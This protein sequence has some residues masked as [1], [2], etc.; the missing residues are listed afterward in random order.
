MCTPCDFVWAGVFTVCM[1]D[2]YSRGV[3]QCARAFVYVWIVEIRVLVGAD[4][5][6]VFG[7][8]FGGRLV[9]GKCEHVPTG[10][11][12]GDL[13]VSSVCLSFLQDPHYPVRPS[14]WSSFPSTG[15]WNAPPP[16]R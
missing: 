16:T 2:A 4:A 5:G 10:A 3:F 7:S 8:G 11:L 1:Q 12:D 13:P 6:A 9:S 15:C 14:S